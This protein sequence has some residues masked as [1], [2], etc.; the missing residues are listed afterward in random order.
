MMYKISNENDKKTI[1]QIDDLFELKTSN[2]EKLLFLID[3]N[4]VIENIC[5][6]SIF[7]GSVFLSLVHF[8]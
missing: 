1:E 2:V 3:E 5:L 4:K 7:Y 6:S 8:Q